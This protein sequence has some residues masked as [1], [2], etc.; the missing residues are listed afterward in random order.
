MTLV[1]A[2]ADRWGV[3]PGPPP[4]KTVWA[5]LTVPP[6]QPATQDPVRPA[7]RLPAAAAT[8]VPSPA[9]IA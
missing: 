8:A 6:R 7:P 1:D 4:C 9:T 5:E 3:I 2:L